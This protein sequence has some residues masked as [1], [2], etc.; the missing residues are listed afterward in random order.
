MNFIYK[1]GIDFGTTNSSIALRSL[2]PQIGLITDCFE[3]DPNGYLRKTLPSAV[4]FDKNGE[5]IL[6]EKRINAIRDENTQLVR[7]IKWE[8]TNPNFSVEVN[9]NSYQAKD[10]V[11][12][13]FKRLRERAMRNTVVPIDGVVLGVPVG[14][15]KDQK[16]AILKALVEAGF[17]HS[18]KEAVAKTEFVS[19]PI[20]V[21]LHYGTKIKDLSRIMVFDFGG[22][23]LDLTIMDLKIIGNKT[24]LDPGISDEV[25]SK[26]GLYLGG[27]TFTR[28]FFERVILS[29]YGL[30][31]M[32][33]DLGIERVNN[34]DELWEAME[35]SESGRLLIKE[36]DSTKITLSYE[37]HVDFYFKHRSLEINEIITRRDFE[38]AI[39]P[40]LP[41]IKELIFKCLRENTTKSAFTPENVDMVLMAGG[42]SLIPV[43]QEMVIDI[44]GRERVQID[45][46]EETLTCIAR[47]LAVAGCQDE[48]RKQKFLDI[49]ESD[50]GIW[51]EINNNIEIILPRNTRVKDTNI[52]RLLLQGYSQQFKTVSKKPTYIRFQVYQDENPIGT[53][54]APISSNGKEGKFEIFFSID[55]KKGWLVI[56]IY[57]R[58]K[59]D[60]MDDIPIENRSFNLTT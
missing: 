31:K 30:Y 38:K 10:I 55:E 46:R 32:A 34:E 2:H 43:I 45:D 27:E 57:D 13:I 9:E 1:Y 18:H 47:G 4:A 37:E 19:E 22:G 48:S 60:W 58:M 44:F 28:L 11:A 41:R 52:D 12:L 51:D 36:L 49:V 17:Y 6:G 15:R 16:G 59:G 33:A 40:E 21:A 53:I 5:P 56:D 20:A 50:Y 25:L 54:E 35:K 29:K 24:E 42:S 39:S 7:K 3:V 26:S 23:T 8:L 14:F